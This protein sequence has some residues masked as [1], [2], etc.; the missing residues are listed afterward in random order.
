MVYSPL[1][2]SMLTG[3]DKTLNGVLP[4]SRAAHGEKLFF[5][6]ELF[7]INKESNSLILLLIV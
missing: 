2:R 5:F 7:F 6:K 4:E 1:E 3:K